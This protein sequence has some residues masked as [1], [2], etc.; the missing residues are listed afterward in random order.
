MVRVPKSPF[1]RRFRDRYSL[2]LHMCA[3]LVA[4]AAIG[5]LASKLLLLARVEN[6][7][8]RYPLAVLFSYL[9][10]F[11]CIKL[12]L[13][14]VTPFAD[15]T[16]RASSVVDGL[17]M[18]IIGTDGHSCASTTPMSGGGG[19]FAGAGASANFD[20][21][22]GAMTEG[23]ASLAVTD[24]A[25]GAA[26]GLGSGVGDVV[27]GAADALGDDGGLVVILAIAV[28]AILLAV[29]LGAS[30]YVIYQAPVILSDA[31]LQGA[32]AA[33]LKN[34]T[35]SLAQGNWHGSVLEATWRPFACTL[36]VALMCGLVLHTYFPTAV[37]LADIW[38]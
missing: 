27:G 10:F 32:L 38:K 16:G 12:W 34:R 9:M 15:S 30:A 7:T 14:Y 33:S 2:R 4:T 28:L 21:D 26:D 37:R 8:F 20:A 22:T 31:A 36:L 11:V 6:F 18:P 29:V 19:E 3:I 17:D 1:L 23:V 35:R 25:S 13:V 5:A 24:A